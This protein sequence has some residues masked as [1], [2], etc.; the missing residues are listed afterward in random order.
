MGVNFD[1]EP[2]RTGYMRTVSVDTSEKAKKEARA[3]FQKMINGEPQRTGYMRPVSVDT[4]EKAKKKGRA[5]FQKIQPKQRSGGGYLVP[6]T[7][8]QKKRNKSLNKMWKKI[9]S[10]PISFKQNNV[11]RK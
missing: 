2:Q 1:G 9:D 6:L 4:S 10:A 8:E 5:M 11:N 3:M 7:E